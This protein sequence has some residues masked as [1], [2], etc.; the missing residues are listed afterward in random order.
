MLFEIAEPVRRRAKSPHELFML[1]LAA[2]HLLLAPAAIVLK[3]GVVGFLLPLLASLAVMTFTYFRARRAASHDPWFVA[4]HWKLAVRRNRILIAAYAF[5][6]ILLGIG[7][8]VAS[9]SDKKTTQE[10]ITTVFARISAVPLLIS[11]MVCFVLESGSIY[12]AMRG[13][14]PDSLLKRLPPP[15]ESTLKPA[16][17][18]ER[19]GPS[20]DTPFTPSSDRRPAS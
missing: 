19:P 16:E 14:V 5:S 15:P 11:V 18:A 4:A 20:T 3:I 1:N 6:G 10:I 9:G 7:L 12:Q 8:M 13:E 2:F 17:P